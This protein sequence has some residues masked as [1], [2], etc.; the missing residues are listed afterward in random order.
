MLPFCIKLLY[1]FILQTDKFI[2]TD[3]ILHQQRQNFSQRFLLQNG[4]PFNLI[5]GNNLG[6]L[7]VVL[8][9]I[10]HHLQGAFGTFCKQFFP[11]FPVE[12][13]AEFQKFDGS[14]F[15]FPAVI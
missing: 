3:L 6:I 5:I 1:T 12:L 14:L 7:T 15:Y 8:D 10:L 11:F 9:L 13:C 4:V 2:H